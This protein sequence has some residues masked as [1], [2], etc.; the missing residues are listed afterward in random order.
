MLA[1]RLRI[2]LSSVWKPWSRV[3]LAQGV[4]IKF[5]VKRGLPAMIAFLQIPK[6]RRSTHRKTLSHS[7]WE[8]II[9]MMQI[10]WHNRDFYSRG[11]LSQLVNRLVLEEFVEFLVHKVVKV[12]RGRAS[13]VFGILN[14]VALTTTSAYL[15]VACSWEI[16]G[17]DTRLKFFWSIHICW[18][19]TLSQTT[20]LIQSLSQN[21]L[22]W[23]E[24]LDLS[25]LRQFDHL[26]GV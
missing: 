13:I 8:T 23:K 5:R 11:G 19:M 15:V 20:S 3:S 7:C 21:Y 12:S 24:V 1:L 9:I 26:C 4:L 16:V 22:R 14:W 10:W 6:Y 25:K 17:F 18:D 2:C